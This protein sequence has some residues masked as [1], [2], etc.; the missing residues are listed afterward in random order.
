MILPTQYQVEGVIK[1]ITS[2]QGMQILKV[3]GRPIN[4][5]TF[6][7]ILAQEGVGPEQT[8]PQGT[9]LYDEEKIK[10]L[11]RK[12]SKKRVPGKPLL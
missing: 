1:L 5:K 3:E 6:K 2:T 4:I 8:L 12:I 7:R 10:R 9:H 11:A